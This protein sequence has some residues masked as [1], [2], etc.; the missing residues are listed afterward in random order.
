MPQKLTG[1]QALQ[2]LQQLFSRWSGNTTQTPFSLGDN[3]DDET[4]S[5]RISALARE[6]DPVGYAN[7]MASLP[8]DASGS[9]NPFAPGMLFEQN[10]ARLAADPYLAATQGNTAENQLRTLRDSNFGNVLAQVASQRIPIQRGT[11]TDIS[12]SATFLPPVAPL[13]PGQKRSGR[14]RVTTTNP[15]GM[16]TAMGSDLIKPAGAWGKARPA[17]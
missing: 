16:W 2:I 8:A 3:E 7:K 9:T 10:R 11:V 1:E 4:V 6:Q 13:L 15:E 12:P 14:S 5:D 17:R